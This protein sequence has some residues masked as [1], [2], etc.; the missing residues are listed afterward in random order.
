MAT[1]KEL[2]GVN[3]QYRDSDATA[4]VGDVWY[5]A[6]TG[7]LKMY[8]G[9]GAIA[10]SNN[11]NTARATFS[12]CGIQTAGMVFAGDEGPTASPPASDAT[13]TYNGSSWTTVADLNTGLS[14]RMGDGTTTAG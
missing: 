8:A 7:L 13:E 6:S 14:Q 9:I 10:S 11:L 2:H 5:N 4:N 3:I 12:G 1:Y